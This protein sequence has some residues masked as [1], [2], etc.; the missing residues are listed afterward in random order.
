MSNPVTPLLP[1]PPG[2]ARIG[3]LVGLQ[4]GLPI[5]EHAGARAEGRTTVPLSEL[6]LGREVLFL[7]AEGQPV[8][9]GLLEQ[10]GA[11][12]EA[13]VDGRRITLRAEE[14]LE[15]VCGE[16]KILLRHNGRIVIS[17]ATVETRAKGTHRIKGGVVKIN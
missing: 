13:T 14:E 1:S 2:A 11:A 5:I 4:A 9:I 8:V 10:P 6:H 17:G 16:A 12:L 15:L 3:R 7:E